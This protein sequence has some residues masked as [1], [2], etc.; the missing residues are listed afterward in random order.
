[1]RIAQNINQIYTLW[2]AVHICP[3]LCVLRS[4]LSLARTD[5]GF[6][7]DGHL[8]DKEEEESYVDKC[9]WVEGQDEPTMVP[10]SGREVESSLIGTVIEDMKIQNCG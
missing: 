8:D 1:M 5:Q 2:P 4:P 9:I 3:L 7:I 10:H 6:T